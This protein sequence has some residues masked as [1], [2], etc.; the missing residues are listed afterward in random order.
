[1]PRSI[2]RCGELLRRRD[3]L[4]GSSRRARDV[5]WRAAALVIAAALAGPVAA[6]PRTVPRQGAAVEE[7]LHVRALL[8][9]AEDERDADAPGVRQ[10]LGAADPELRRRGALALGRI[11]DPASLPLLASLLSDPAPLVRHEA[12]FALGQ[13]GDAGAAT[14]LAHALLARDPELRGRAAEALARLSWPTPAERRAA[15]ALVA[16]RVLGNERCIA[17]MPPA[18]LGRALRQAWRFGAGTAGLP[19][20]LRRLATHPDDGVAEAATHAA[21]RLADDEVASLLAS[22]LDDPRSRVAASAARGLGRIA[23][24]GKGKA[25]AAAD[26]ARHRDRLVAA[27]AAPDVATRVAAL[28][29]LPSFEAPVDDGVAMRALR[30][31]LASAEHGIQ[32]AALALAA[33]W[34]VAAAA[35][36]ARRFVAGDRIDLV[37]E[38]AQAL[39]AGRGVD[40]LPDVR[41]LAA[42]PDWRRRAAAAEALADA[43]LGALPQALLAQDELLGDADARVAAAAL[44]AAVQSGRPDAARLALR[45][46]D[47]DD[48]VVR[49]VAASVVPQLVSQGLPRADATAALRGAIDRARADRDLDARISALEA[50]VDV[51]SDEARADVIAATRDRDLVVRRTARTLWDEVGGGAAPPEMG[52]TA[53]QRPLSFYLDAAR[54]EAAG[55]PLTLTLA[56]T[57]GEVA[58]RLAADVAPLTVRQL[59]TLAREGYLDG[60]TFHRVVPEF[61]VQGGCPRGDGWGGPGRTLRCETH[62]GPYA[63]GAVGMA[64][65]GK[66]T[67]GSQFFVTLSPQPHL[68]GRYTIFG[69]VDEDGMAVVDE[70]LR[71][72]VIE[73]ATVTPP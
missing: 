25:E 13:V 11:G 49:A 46:L 59:A 8:L 60:L 31:N 41:R 65:S 73:R 3:D 6:S 64:L 4:D 34:K 38:A 32:R 1:M 10:A 17:G 16:R 43:R 39:V 2:R 47:H 70:I 37:P 36:D 26:L 30:A 21:S 15:G 61:V 68:E 14:T 23:A 45:H 52:V 62:D 48:V 7:G 5:P 19:D 28:Q 63:R 42:S 56:T 12:A 27:C 54:A 69:S 35:E 57:R 29:A 72:D 71:F 33:D 66:D 51:A 53:T 44:Q 18:A 22:A 24:A 9:R 50:L 58:V 40:A 55:E 67:G 20:A